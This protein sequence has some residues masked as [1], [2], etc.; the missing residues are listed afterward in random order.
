MNKR[1]FLNSFSGT[2]L[3]VINILSMFI[4]SPVII[5]AIGNR[6]YGLWEMILGIV[7]YLGIFDLGISPALV[8]FVSVAYGRKNSQELQIVI[9]TALVFFL[10]IG[11][12]ISIALIVF[13]FNFNILYYF[14]Y[15]DVNRLQVILI[16]VTA[17]VGILFPLNVFSSTLMGI[18]K[19]YEINIT[20]STLTVCRVIIVLFFIKRYPE[21]GLLILVGFELVHNII[22][23]I[24]YIFALIFDKSVPNI[25][26]LH[27]SKNSM[28]NMIK[29]G[30]KSTLISASSLLQHTT[31]PFIIGKTIGI[32]MIVYYMLPSR[33][34]SYAR[35]LSL[36]IGFPLLPY[37]GSCF[38]KEGLVALRDNWVKASMVFQIFT[39][40]LPVFV[41]F[42]GS[43]FLTLWVGADYGL[44]G[45][46]VINILL[47]GLIV[48]SLAPNATRVL[49]A[50]AIHGNL[51]I[52][53]LIISLVC[54]PMTY[55]GATYFGIEGVAIGTSIV[56]VI[57]YIVTL[58]MAC[59]AVGITLA[60]YFRNT[61]YKLFLPLVGLIIM[62]FMVREYLHADAYLSIIIGVV[63]GYL[64]YIV[65]ILFI[66]FDVLTR[67]HIFEMIQNKVINFF[68][69]N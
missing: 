14:N 5:K 67:V 52:F 28:K 66:S 29:Y 38:G 2:L 40:S 42:Y 61:T 48:E 47:V 69:K 32:D 63:L 58:M 35:G 57:G 12:V 25:S 9:S 68:K 64:F 1:I 6:E 22:Q 26:F 65:L 54:I 16:V 4:M 17:N 8:R 45:Q 13:I 19:H 60:S 24:V 43:P 59:S 62:M 39:L 50:M 44:Q 56:T 18:Q 23:S 36:A 20:K 15:N 3:Y 10:I 51:A 11:S 34:I 27:A 21:N 31:I 7:G 37:F 41:Y 55:L 53:W 30:I 33:L 46:G 49:M